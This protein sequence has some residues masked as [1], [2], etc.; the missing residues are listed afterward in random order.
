[1]LPPVILFD[2]DDTILDDTGGASAAWEQAC[3]DSGAPDGLYDAIRAAGAWFWSDPDRHR[4]GRADLLEARRTI[5]ATA[6]QNLGL[7]DDGLSTRISARL[8]ALRDE[9]I[10]PLPGAIDTLEVLRAGGVRL[11]LLTNGSARHQRWKI[12]RFSLESQFDYVGIEG[13]VGVGKPDPESYLRALRALAVE[14]GEAWMVGD[15][16]VFDVGGAQAVGMHGV[17]VDV[18]ARGL[19]DTPVAVPDRIVTSIAELVG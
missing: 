5:A 11:G 15:N 1:M 16:L 6:L 9:A 2:L 14:P 19:P 13:E 18:R 17:W 8:N 4:T 12:E 10:A 7:P 3:I